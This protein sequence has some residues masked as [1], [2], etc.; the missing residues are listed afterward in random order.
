MQV[1][2]SKRRAK[3]LAAGSIQYVN[4]IGVWYTT[5]YSVVEHVV[6]PIGTKPH[7]SFEQALE[8]GNESLNTS[9]KDW[10]TIDEGEVEKYILDHAK[11]TWR[12]TLRETSS[13]PGG[14]SQQ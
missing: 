14:D 9:P 13:K 7:D 4:E 1:T 2:I 10:I 6:V 8:D 11:N 12:P 5:L 3:R